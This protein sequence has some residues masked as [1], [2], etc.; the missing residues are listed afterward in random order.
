MSTSLLL[1][2]CGGVG[3]AV[4]R[5]LQL[6]RPP[7][8][9]PWGVADRSGLL[10]DADPDAVIA[11]KE[12]SGALRTLGAAAWRW[13]DRPFVLID[14]ATGDNR[15]LWLE[16]IARGGAVVTAN[17]VPLAA[18]DAPWDRW[19][20]Q[21]RA[22]RLHVGGTV[23]AGVPSASYLR[24]LLDGGDAI[25]RIEGV[26][27]GTLHFVV[28]Q[29][30]AGASLADAVD[31]AAA[32]GFTEPDPALDLSGADVGRKLTIL[33]RLASLWPDAPTREVDG[34]IPATWR[35]LDRDALRARL[36]ELDGPL[37]ARIAAA[38][39]RGEVLRYVGVADATGVRC[40]LVP[41]PSE[42][43]LGRLGPAENGVALT[44]RRF[45]RVVTSIT[46]PGFG[47][48]VT[49]RTLLADAVA[50]AGSLR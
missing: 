42:G 40:G 39:E 47:P 17:K 44:S 46:G 38:R 20:P 7:T 25:T 9:A 28:G 8:L 11:H 23:G 3:R 31:E 19:G 18:D 41:M 2:G 22:G 36:R 43:P 14:A 5:E 15:A 32:R 1:L 12:A 48:E 10:I 49:A 26:V 50:A 34:V 6:L 21:W 35:G 29:A 24:A 45:D 27:S 13:P 4:L 30:M 37:R 33:G 16:A